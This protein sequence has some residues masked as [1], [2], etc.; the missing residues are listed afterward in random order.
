MEGEDGFE[1]MR[2]TAHDCAGDKAEKEHGGPT[3]ETRL[4]PAGLPPSSGPAL[5]SRGVAAGPGCAPSA[6]LTLPWRW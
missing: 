5:T 4:A 6:C 1:G 3:R 2:G